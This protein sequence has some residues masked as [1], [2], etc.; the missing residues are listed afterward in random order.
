ML[1]FGRRRAESGRECQWKVDNSNSPQRRRGAEA[2]QRTPHDFTSPRCLCVSAVNEAALTIPYETNLS[3]SGD[4]HELGRLTGEIERFCTDHSLPRDV[5]FQLNLVLEE[6]FVNAVQHGGCDGMV[7]AARIRMRV[8]A[9]RT[10]QV[11]FFDRGAPFDLT[12]VP[13]ADIHA[14]LSERRAG[15]MGIHLVRQIMRDVSY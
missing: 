3:L 8:V 9:G 10:V 6:L 4:I 2:T 13:E 12:Q 1:C 14:P 11:V 5:E 7:N 15:G